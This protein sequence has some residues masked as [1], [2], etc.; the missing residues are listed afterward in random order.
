VVAR[1]DDDGAVDVPLA[2]GRST[3]TATAVDQFGVTRTT[4]P[5]TIA[6]DLVIDTAGP[7]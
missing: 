6:S 1:E 2:D 3:I 7:R 4:A 5:V